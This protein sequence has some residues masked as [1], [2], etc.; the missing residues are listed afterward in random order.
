MKVVHFESGLGNQML[1]Y[2]EYLAIKQSNPEDKCYMENIL[3]DIEKCHDVICMWNGYELEKIFGISIPNI[4]EIFNESQWDRIIADIN[5]SNF[6][7]ENWNYSD[8]IISAFRKENINLN[9]L[10]KSQRQKNQSNLMIFLRTKLKYFWK[11]R[12]GYLLKRIFFKIFEKK[13]INKQNNPEELFIR[14]NENIFCGQ[15]LKFLRKGYGIEKIEDELINSFVF[16]EIVDKENLEILSIIEGVN[17]V[18]IHVRRGD[19]LNHNKYL[20]TGGY[21][22][23]AVKYIK[24]NVAN[25]V[26]FVFSDPGSSEWCKNN[27]EIFGLNIK[28]DCIH[29]IDWNKGEESYR[30]MQLM[31]KCKHNI[32]TNSSFGWWGAFLNRNVDK[33]TCSPYVGYYTTNWF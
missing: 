21:F 1:N 24:N 7:E 23:R 27:L 15:T 4:K 8:A 18:S 5:K 10:C 25:P 22:K 14:T 31:S 17:S 19:M 6:W 13:I 2:A 33:I 20:Y 29:F 26:F 3:Y 32:I 9:N 16:P 30:D 11:T 12:L 28:N